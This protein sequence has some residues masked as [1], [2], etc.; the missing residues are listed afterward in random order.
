M[1]YALIFQ[2][3]LGLTLSTAFC[4]SGRNGNPGWGL[5]H[6]LSPG[7]ALP[8]TTAYILYCKGERGTLRTNDR[9]TYNCTPLPLLFCPATD[10]EDVADPPLPR[11]LGNLAFRPD[12]QRK[13]TLCPGGA[14]PERTIS[15]TTDKITYKEVIT[16]ENEIF[17]P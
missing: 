12:R 14:S 16:N 3:V 2:A 10:Q 9:G 13:R 6:G 7:I 17:V 15:Y 5:K 11:H 8:G 4:V 1:C